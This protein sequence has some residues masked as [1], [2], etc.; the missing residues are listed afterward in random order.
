MQHLG[1]FGCS[2]GRVYLVGKCDAT[3]LRR[4]VVRGQVLGR[5]CTCALPMLH[6]AAPRSHANASAGLR[7]VL[8]MEGARQGSRGT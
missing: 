3:M 4:T 1:A 7:H 8:E 5:A 2:A 6:I